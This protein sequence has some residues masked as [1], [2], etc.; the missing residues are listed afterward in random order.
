MAYFKAD[1]NLKFG[2]KMGKFKHLFK[3]N[4]QFQFQARFM[5]T[6]DKIKCNSSKEYVYPNTSCKISVVGRQVY[7][8]NAYH[9]I[10]KQIDQIFVSHLQK[11]AWNS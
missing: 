3:L 4:F 11:Y 7:E 5:G 2:E 9:K 8:I 1:L 6:F 10:R